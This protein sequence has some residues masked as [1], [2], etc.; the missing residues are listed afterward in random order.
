[1]LDAA[2][3]PCWR[4]KMKILPP[5]KIGDA[6]PSPTVSFH[7]SLSRSGQAAGA[8]ALLSEPSRCGPRHC[9]QSSDHAVAA[10][11]RVSKQTEHHLYGPGV[12][13]S[14]SRSSHPFL[15][16]YRAYARGTTLRASFADNY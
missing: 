7:F 16:T 13:A 2:S 5:A 9:G 4:V 8:A 12:I 6:C 11:S 14:A 15:I 1:M 3:F 10:G